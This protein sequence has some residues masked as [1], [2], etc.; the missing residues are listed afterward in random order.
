MDGRLLVKTVEEVVLLLP[1]LNLIE[2]SLSSLAHSLC[3]TA[4][5]GLDLISLGQLHEGLGHGCWVSAVGTTKVKVVLVR[6]VK[7]AAH[8][9]SLHLAGEVGALAELEE[10]EG[11]EVVV[12]VLHLH[13]L[14][15][16]FV[17]RGNRGHLLLPHLPLSHHVVFPLLLELV[18]KSLLLGELCLPAPCS[19]RTTSGRPRSPRH[20]ALRRRYPRLWVPPGLPIPSSYSS[21]PSFPSSPSSLSCHGRLLPQ[22]A[23]RGVMREGP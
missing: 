18:Q 21:S 3:Q 8:E 9:E 15:S 2:V 17:V 10:L 19:P 4:K 1:G 16:E 22:G 13:D 11:H 12:L 23:G 14:I 6:V 20:S 5:E 7:V